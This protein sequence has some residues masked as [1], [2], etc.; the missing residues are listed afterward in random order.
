MGEKGYL[1]EREVKRVCVRGGGVCESGGKRE[2]GCEV[3]KKAEL[4]RRAGT[5][6]ARDRE[7]GGRI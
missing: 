5:G 4:K 7:R 6:R 3:E 2:E 1:E